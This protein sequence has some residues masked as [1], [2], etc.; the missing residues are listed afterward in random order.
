MN[1]FW[2]KVAGG[3]VAVVVLIVL[4]NVFSPSASK[5]EPEPEPSIGAVWERDEERLRADPRPKE[6]QPPIEAQEPG[7]Q[8]AKPK[9]RELSEIERI[10]AERL[11]NVALQHRKIGRLQGIG[12]KQ[13]VEYCRMIIERYPDSE[14]AFKAKRMLADIPVRFR[15][16]FNVT[17]EETDLGDWK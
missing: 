15:E 11:F 10:D 3:A 6:P 9:F 14:Y 4:M 16:R 7:T 2:L 5:A 12:Y 17:L 13:M 1:T 8:P